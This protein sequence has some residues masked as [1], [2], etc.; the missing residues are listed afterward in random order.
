MS[1]LLAFLFSVALRD[2]EFG[3]GFG[4]F[5]DGIIIEAGL[6]AGYAAVV[7]CFHI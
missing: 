1:L 6:I 7:R 3:Y 5:Y 4:L 2:I